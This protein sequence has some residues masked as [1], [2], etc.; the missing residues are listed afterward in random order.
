MALQLVRRDYVRLIAALQGVTN[1]RHSD[2]NQH[3]PLPDR[4][5][6]WW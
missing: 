3:G 2:W 5:S 1:A 4:P 6:P